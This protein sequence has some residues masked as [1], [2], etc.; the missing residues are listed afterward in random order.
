MSK[1]QIPLTPEQLVKLVNKYNS[2]PIQIYDEDGIRATARG[3]INAFSKKF[4]KGFKEFY[5][6]KALPNP[7]V[8][9]ILL[10]EGCGLDCSSA[11]EL[12]IAKK[13][14]VKGEDVMYTSNYTSK[15]DLAFAYDYGVNIN[16]DDISLI[17][18]LI[19]VRGRVPDLISFRLN[20]GVGRT[21]SETKS[22]VLGGPEAKFG[23]PPFQI[24]DAYRKAKENGATR[25]GIHMMT[26]S[27]VT[28]AE[29]WRDTVTILVNTVAKLRKELDIEFE[30]INIG[31]G[32]GIPYRE[33][34]PVVNL[35]EVT[36]I[37]Q[38][39]F[40]SKIDGQPFWGEN[41]NNEPK[42]YMENGRYLT[43]PHGYLVASC[44][45]VKDTYEKYYGLDACMA[46]LMRPG[47]YGAYH[48]I[49]VPTAQNQQELIN[50][51][52]VGSLCEN[53]DWFAKNR[54][55]PS[56]AKVGDLFVI[57][58]TGAHSFSMGFNYNGKLHAPEVIIYKDENG[59][60]QD[61]L[62]RERQT[63]ESQFFDAKISDRLTK[64]SG[65]AFSM[66]DSN[67]NNSNSSSSSNVSSKKDD[68][69]LCVIC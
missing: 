17:D 23:V 31:G 6:V 9:R 27:C 52:V 19:Q 39:V 16:L 18:S 69:S 46:N 3:L 58:D 12:Y 5:A 30:F 25:F 1:K 36:N 48:A 32:L 33:G 61:E 37:I 29:Y 38:E 55:I 56:S 49:T 53:N 63:I 13:L 20:P 22:N 21:D 60:Y 65:I 42:L 59:E 7:A 28:N 41:K 10:D 8:L 47:M 57:H 11:T 44:E 15:K 51:N 24:V 50:A 34:E 4:N 68:D 43:G 64:A 45:A 14:G 54:P 66:D 62:V 26:G 40:Y 2:T 67:N 35:E